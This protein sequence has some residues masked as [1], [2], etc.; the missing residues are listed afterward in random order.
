MR[1]S[2]RCSCIEKRDKVLLTF[3]LGEVG[4]TS[5]LLHMRR[6]GSVNLTSIQFYGIKRI[7]TVIT[8][9]WH[10]PITS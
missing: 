1:I 10:S 4:A 8:R 5:D 6:E 3:R 2:E 7:G 9:L